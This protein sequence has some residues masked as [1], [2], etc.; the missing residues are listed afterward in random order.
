[1]KKREILIL[2]IIFIFFGCSNSTYKQT[3]SVLT[4]GKYDNGFPYK[5]CSQQLEEISKS[6]KKINC[7]IEYDIFRF[8]FSDNLTSTNLESDN[9]FDSRF[10]DSSIIEAGFGTA[11]LIYSDYQHQVLLTCAHVLDYEDTI[12]TYYNE[13]NTHEE[14]AVAQIAIKKKQQFF[15]K[16]GSIINQFSILEM[17]KTNDIALLSTKLGESSLK[18]QGAIN[19]PVGNS[20]ELQWG[21]FVYI[22]GYPSGV[23]MVT[24]GIVS[25]SASNKN[26][27]LIDALFNKGFSGGIVLAVRDGVPNFEIVGMI[28][29]AS[30]TYKNILIPDKQSH[31]NI[32]PLSE[33]YSGDVYADIDKRINYGVTYATSIEAII[34]F[35]KSKRNNLNDLGYGLDTFFNH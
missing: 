9:K 13:L 25:K 15:L 19:Y 21:D 11:T 14:K 24:K 20:R 6:V 34:N 28:Q 33:E 17:D 27:F 8:S 7:Y 2:L 26:V 30:A 5:D 4:D 23:Q 12:Y 16:D 35:Y 31:E 22:M 3:Y 32:Y 29:S 18:Q 1:M 10:P